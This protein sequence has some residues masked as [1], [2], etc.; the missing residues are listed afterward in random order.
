MRE[1]FSAI[2]EGVALEFGLCEEDKTSASYKFG[3]Q[4]SKIG[5]TPTLGREPEWSFLCRIGVDL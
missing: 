2:L 4:E 1:N 5:Q 3:E